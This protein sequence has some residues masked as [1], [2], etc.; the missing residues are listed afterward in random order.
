MAYRVIQWATGAMGKSCLR[1]VIDHPAM[2][3]VGLY[4]YGDDKVGR[5]AGDIARRPPSGVIATRDADA[6]LALDADVVIHAARLAPPYGSHDADIL[7]LLASGKNVI[8]INGYSRPQHWA[9]DRLAA[10]Q[11][12]CDMGGTSLMA[13]GLN[14]GFAAE[15][16]AVV[17]TGVC[18]QL[19]HIEIVESVDCRAVRNPDYVFRVLGFGSDPRAVDPNDPSW[20]PA[21]SL[22][23]MYVEVLS[24][25]AEHLGLALDRIDTDHVVLPAS[26]DLH[27]AAGPIPEGRV[28]HVNWRWRA[29][30]GGAPKLTMS[31]HWYME[32]AHLPDPAPPLWRIHVTGQPGVRIAIDLEKRPGD[33]TPT[34]AEQLGVAGMVLNA[35]PIVCAAAPGVVTR[36]LATPFRGDLQ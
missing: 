14:P 11:A 5:D 16:I 21:S 32:T 15:Q 7:A 33:T 8:S 12:A 26:A 24:A 23:G 28:S 29:I 13:A 19:D 22:N 18:A 10:L 35:I 25:M 20:G 30:V 34:S 1:A 27:T 4:V 31:I 3:L 9:G 36:P 6:I 2:E 17:A